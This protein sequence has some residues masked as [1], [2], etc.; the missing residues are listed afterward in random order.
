M[1]FGFLD[2]RADTATLDKTVIILHEFS[3][4]YAS[5]EL[6]YVKIGQRIKNSD[7]LKLKKV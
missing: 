5:F 2:F 6:Q 7:F 3:L 4:N 1:A